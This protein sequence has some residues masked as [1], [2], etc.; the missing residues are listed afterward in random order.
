M[1]KFAWVLFPFLITN[2]TVGFC[3]RITININ[4]NIV[5]RSCVISKN[6]SDFSVQLGM[7]DL[8]GKEIGVPFNKTPFSIILEDCPENLSFANLTFI[9][10]S[11]EELPGLLK[12]QNKTK[13]SAKGVTIG[14]YDMKNQIIDIRNNKLSIEIKKNQSSN[15]F[16]FSSYYIKT[17]NEASAGKIT[18]IVNFEIYYD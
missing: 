2:S 8:K 7:G 18:G 6:T 9:G 13:A 11:D 4:G 1:N 15:K 17:N 16:E 12:N 3:E 14:L 10:E 5:E